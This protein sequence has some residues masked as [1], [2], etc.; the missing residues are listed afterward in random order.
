MKIWI[1]KIIIRGIMKKKI[2]KMWIVQ[3]EREDE[4]NEM[5]ILRIREREKYM[6]KLMNEKKKEDWNNMDISV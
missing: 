1:M 4:N 5:E 2:E 6:V 3:K